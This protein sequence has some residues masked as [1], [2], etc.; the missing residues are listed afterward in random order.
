MKASRLPAKL[1]QKFDASDAMLKAQQTLL[2]N[3]AVENER[4]NSRFDA[5]KVRLEPMWKGAAPGS[6]AI[7]A[8]GAGA[9]LRA[10]PAR[11]APWPSEPADQPSLPFSSWLTWAGLA[12]PLLAFM[13]WPT[14]ALNA[15][16]LPARYSS[17][18]F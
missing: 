15:L 4:I 2:Q 10:S 9:A 6:M 12:L 14:S 11:R 1:K 5:E 18:D 17:T 7:A 13:I 16:S 3:Q 8:Q